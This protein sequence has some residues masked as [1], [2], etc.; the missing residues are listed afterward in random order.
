MIVINIVARNVFMIT[1]TITYILFYVHG[2]QTYVICPIWKP[3][4]ILIAIIIRCI[5][6]AVDI[7]I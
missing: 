5:I 4:N 2:Y 1:L 7:S 6:H 3:Q